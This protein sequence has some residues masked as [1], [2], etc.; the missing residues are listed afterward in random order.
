MSENND[1]KVL[2]QQAFELFMQELHSRMQEFEIDSNKTTEFM[3]EALKQARERLPT[4]NESD[5]FS[6]P[7]PDFDDE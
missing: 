2:S 4:G 6:T 7:Q 5:Y 3:N 1:N